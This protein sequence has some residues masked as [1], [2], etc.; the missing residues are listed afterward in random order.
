MLINSGDKTTSFQD[1]VSE[2][3]RK[4]KG[5]GRDII[6]LLGFKRSKMKSAILWDANAFCLFQEE[7]IL[8][9]GPK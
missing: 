7:S 1:E 3:E 2:G 4:I 5:Y 9:K 6:K 8:M